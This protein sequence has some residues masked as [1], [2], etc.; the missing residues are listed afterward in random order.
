MPEKLLTLD[1]LSEYLQIKKK[2][3]N[4]LVDKGVI[5]AYRIGGELLRFRKEQID[6]IKSEIDSRIAEKDRLLREEGDNRT[7]AER[8]RQMRRKGNESLRDKVSDFLYFNDFYILSACI[9]AV[10][11]VVIFR[12]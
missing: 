1:E 12:R 6:A 5:S 4:R 3:L 10:L 8:L 11:L 9:I 7:G 2:T